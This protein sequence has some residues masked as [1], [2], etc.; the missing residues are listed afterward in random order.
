MTQRAVNVD[1]DQALRSTFLLLSLVVGAAVAFLVFALF[2]QTA[3]VSIVRIGLSIGLLLAISLAHYWSG[4]KWLLK[5]LQQ[6]ESDVRRA[7]ALGLAIT[8]IFLPMLYSAPAYPVSPLLRPWAEVA[9]QFEVPA[10]SEPLVLPQKDLRLIMGKEVVDANAFNLVGSWEKTAAGLRLAPGSTG[11]LQWT[12]TIADTVTLSLQPPP[13]NSTLTIYWNNIR[14]STDI[15]PGNQGQILIV[16]K[17][18][19]PWGYNLALFISAFVLTAWVLVLLGLAPGSRLKVLS[20]LDTFKALPWIVLGLSLLLAGITVKLQIDSLS[21]GLRYLT[22]TQLTRHA[23]VLAGQAPN[24]W[25]YR[26]LSEWIAE[27]LIRISS[28]LSIP[29]P[30]VVAFISL[31]IIQN[32][33]IFLLAFALYKRVTGSGP[34]GVLGIL[35]LAGSMANAYY[36]NDLAFNTYFDVIFYLVCALLLL[37]RKY[38]AV[39]ILTIF[40]ALNRETSGLIPFLMMAAIVEEDHNRGLGKFV[41][42]LLAAGLFAGIFFALRW[43]FPGRPIYIPYKHPPGVALLLYNLTRQFTW[44]QLWRTLGFVPLLGL[45]FVSAWPR[46]WQRFLL[47][48]CPAWFAVHAFGSVMAETRLFLVPASLVFIPGALFMLRS[49]IDT[50]ELV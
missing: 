23:N 10:S 6:P 38:Y 19:L 2:L 47:I 36:D 48:L 18:P 22:T 30:A 28:A 43:V 7:L 24:P 15:H 16:E 42:A 25:Q 44:D 37:S 40:A 9:V 29:S 49:F 35:V 32:L 20:Q 3:A 12:G 8:A 50:K 27:A 41:P 45:A 26:V 1:Q 13:T 21:G 33:A 5:R 34:L 46:L 39:V 11:S 31:R 17:A 14:T 4:F